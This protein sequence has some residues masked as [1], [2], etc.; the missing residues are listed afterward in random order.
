MYASWWY[1]FENYIII[2]DTNIPNIEHNLDENEVHTLL[3]AWEMQDPGSGDPP[4]CG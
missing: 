2:S 1:I 3:L 4:I